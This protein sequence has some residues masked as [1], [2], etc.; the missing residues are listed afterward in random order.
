[1]LVLVLLGLCLGSFVNAAVWRF[2]E[3]QKL[4]K[5]GKKPR[6]TPQDLSIS[7]GRSLC[8]RCGHQL[9]SRDL[10]PVLS[11]IMLRGRCR[12]CHKAISWQYPFVELLAA[13]LFVV[14][15]IFW[16]VALQGSAWVLFGLWL[17]QVVVLMALAVYDAHWQLLPTKMIAILAC[18]VAPQLL[19]EAVQAPNIRQWALNALLAAAIGGG[20]FEIL[21]RVSNGKWIG[22]GDIRLGV[23]LGLIVGHPIDSF[24]I[25]FLASLL[26]TILALPWLVRGALKVSAKL[27]FGPLLIVATFIVKLWG[28]A[29]ID[30][31]MRLVGL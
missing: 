11:W 4:K 6:F 29:L 20:I 16:P 14:S 10:V 24:L 31:Y 23:W 12:Y 5:K 3:Q 8:P 30:W 2:H 13:V 19:I 26:G 9:A 28:G 21:Y 7:R 17:A 1:M 18:T 27:P 15:Y 22:G 25:I